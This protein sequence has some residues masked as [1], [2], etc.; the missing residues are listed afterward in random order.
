[1]RCV[2][3]HLFARSRD[4]CSGSKAAVAAA[5]ASTSGVPQIADDLLHG[6][7]SSASDQIRTLVFESC[8][9]AGLKSCIDPSNLCV[10]R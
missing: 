5:L 9:Y 3:S 6:T 7:K 4:I 2:R 1:M 8:T 10:L